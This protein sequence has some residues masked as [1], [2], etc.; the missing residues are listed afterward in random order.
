MG[1]TTV[2]H[3]D[4]WWAVPVSFGDRSR[5]LVVDTAT[6]AADYVLEADGIGH[7]EFHP[8]DSEWFRYA[9]SYRARIW[10]ARRDGSREPARLRTGRRRQGVDRARD[11]A[12]RARGR[13]SPRS[14]RTA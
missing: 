9:G 10:V 12:A 6:G 1:T 5:M 4:R 8:D 13:S 7:P 2:S 14:G 3:D 11:V